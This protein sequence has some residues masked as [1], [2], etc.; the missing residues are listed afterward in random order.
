M[1]GLLP[2]EV[3]SIDRERRIARVRIPGL[4]D[5]AAELPEA[6]FCNPIGDVSEKTEIRILPGDRVWLAFQGGDTR[7]PVIVGYRPKQDSNGIDWRRFA[8]ANFEF[9]ADNEF[10][11][12]AGTKVAVTAPVVLVDSPDSTFTG[13]VTV[14]GLFTYQAGISGTSGAAG[15]KISGGMTVTDGDVTVDG[16]GVKSHHHSDPQGG[17]TG[18]ALA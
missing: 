12:I 3:D 4:T 1:I 10:R 6:E 14:K 17:N 11:I 18:G 8:H 9:N 13:K 16:I 7:Y 5:G 2:A 15:S